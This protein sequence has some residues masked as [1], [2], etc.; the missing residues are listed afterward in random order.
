MSAVEA[1]ENRNI[2]VVDEADCKGKDDAI[3]KPDAQEASGLVAGILRAAAC[4]RRAP[5]QREVV[6]D[7][8]RAYSALL[9]LGRQIASGKDEPEYSRMAWWSDASTKEA[10]APVF[11]VAPRGPDGDL[12]HQVDMWKLLAY[13]VSQMNEHVVDQGLPYALVWVQLS[14]H[15]IWSF[16][17]LWFQRSLHA[18]FSSNLDAVHVVHPS[19]GVRWLRLA[20]WPLVAEEMWDHFYSHERIEFLESYVNL[21][22]L[23]LPGDLYEYDKFLD[24]Y[25][26]LQCEEAQVHLGRGAPAS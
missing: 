15:R 18:A 14:D 21:D 19:W 1:T 9:K 4:R 8:P 23:N 7:A 20:L 22:K 3:L 17:A 13:S 26:K 24:E 11:V 10:G 12:E 2:H 6:V 16:S 25:A 5:A